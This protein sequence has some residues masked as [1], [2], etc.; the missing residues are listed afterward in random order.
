MANVNPFDIYHYCWHTDGDPF[1]MFNLETFGYS[2]EVGK[3]GQI[4]NCLDRS[5]LVKYWNDETAREAFHVSSYNGK[6]YDCSPI[7]KY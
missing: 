1:E 5:G 3:N 7:L 6:W 2:R 4:P